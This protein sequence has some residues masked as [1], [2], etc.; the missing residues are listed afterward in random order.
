MLQ[1][2][3]SIPHAHPAASSA[4][5]RA[6]CMAS[7]A[8]ACRESAR[9]PVL[10]ESTTCTLKFLPWVNSSQIYPGCKLLVLGHSWR[11]TAHA[12]ALSSSTAEKQYSNLSF[13]WDWE[14][15]PCLINRPL[16]IQNGSEE[17]VWALNEEES[18]PKPSSSKAQRCGGWSWAAGGAG[19]AYFQSCN[20]N[21]VSKLPCSLLPFC[22]RYLHC[23]II[24]GRVS[25]PEFISSDLLLPVSGP[26]AA[27][28]INPSIPAAGLV[29]CQPLLIVR[30]YT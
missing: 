8:P 5:A 19:L 17:Q 4:C 13:F 25:L 9:S 6:G 28:S 2:T 26:R 23:S 20:L 10:A 7:R 30:Q 21:Y 16:A 27:A 24:T 18:V 11:R 12:A 15:P 1:L 3:Q 29:G 22:A 14:L